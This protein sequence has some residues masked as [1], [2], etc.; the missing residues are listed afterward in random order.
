MGSVYIVVLLTDKHNLWGRLREAFS[1]GGEGG[2]PARRMRG[3]VSE[4]SPLISHLR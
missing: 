4:K 3:E 1:L 2:A